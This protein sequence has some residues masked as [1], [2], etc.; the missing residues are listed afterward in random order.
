M[1][2]EDRLS[3]VVEGDTGTRRGRGRRELRAGNRRRLLSAPAPEIFGAESGAEALIFPRAI[4]WFTSP[5]LY[6]E[7]SLG[8]W[9][10]GKGAKFVGEV[11]SFAC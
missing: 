6:N 9:P 8:D 5:Y 4:S 7:R 1:R 3:E 10:I 11:T 2:R